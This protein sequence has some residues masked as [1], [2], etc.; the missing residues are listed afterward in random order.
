MDDIKK[1]T[2][3]EGVMLTPL[4]IITG[5]LGSVRHAMKQSDPGFAGFGEAYF[6][7]VNPGVVKGWK[8]HSKM[9][10]NLVVV[11]GSISFM[12]FDDRPESSTRGICGI[13]KLSPENYYRLTVPAGVWLAF[14]GESGGINM[15][16][17]LASIMHV[18]DE[19]ENRDLRHP[20]MPSLLI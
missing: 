14:K 11:Q 4:K 16:L 13:A 12:A 17:N 10:L 18:P 15:L 1:I 3:I 19:A 2:E 6:S 20:S 9:V 8:R 5:D 7:T